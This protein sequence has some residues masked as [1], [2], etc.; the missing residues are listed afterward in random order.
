MERQFHPVR[1]ISKRICA[2]YFCTNFVHRAAYCAQHH[3][4]YRQYSFRPVSGPWDVAPEPARSAC[5]AH[6]AH[7][8]H[9]MDRRKTLRTAAETEGKR[10]HS[11]PLCFRWVVKSTLDEIE[12]SRSRRDPRSTR[13]QLML[14]LMAYVWHTRA[15]WALD[16]FF[17]RLRVPILAKIAYIRSEITPPR[18]VFAAFPVLCCRFCLCPAAKK[19]LPAKQLCFLHSALLSVLSKVWPADVVTGHIF[20]WVGGSKMVD[21]FAHTY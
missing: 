18:L 9:N 11:C 19:T 20:P 12:R 10:E 17:Y 4:V 21:S 15:V 7:K 16:R 6:A 8:R 2:V 1:V 13:E 5:R 14:G 3:A